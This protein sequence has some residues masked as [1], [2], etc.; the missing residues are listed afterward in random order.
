MAL[1]GDSVWIW[2]LLLGGAS[3]PLQTPNQKVVYECAV[4]QE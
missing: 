4:I 1:C 2:K 3:I